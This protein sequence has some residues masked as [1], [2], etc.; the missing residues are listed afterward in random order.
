MKIDS[1]LCYYF[2]AAV[3]INVAS[4]IAKHSLSNHLLDVL[5][6]LVGQFVVKR[7][8]RTVSNSVVNGR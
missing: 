7:R 8:Y 4:K 2:T 6:T 1:C 3:F 5:T